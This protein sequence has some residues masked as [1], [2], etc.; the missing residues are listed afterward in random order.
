MYY[1]IEM[2]NVKFWG[3]KVEVQGHSGITYA[4]TIT[5]QAGSIQYLTS[6]VELDCFLCYVLYSPQ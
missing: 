1:G 3:Q 6:C 2:N 5:A 4:G